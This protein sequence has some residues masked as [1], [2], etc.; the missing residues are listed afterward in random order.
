MFFP[1]CHPLSDEEMEEELQTVVHNF[2]CNAV[3]P[4][5]TAEDPRQF[6][7]TASADYLARE[8]TDD[9]VKELSI[10]DAEMESTFDNFDH[11]DR[12]ERWFRDHPDVWRRPKTAEP[13]LPDRNDFARWWKASRIEIP[14]MQLDSTFQ[15]YLV[16]R[17]MDTEVTAEDT[18]KAIL[19]SY[20]RSIGVPPQALAPDNQQEVFIQRPGLVINQRSFGTAIAAASTLF[21]NDTMRPLRSGEANWPPSLRG[22]QKYVRDNVYPDLS[23]DGCSLVVEFSGSQSRKVTT[24]QINKMHKTWILEHVGRILDSGLT[25]RGEN[26]EKPINILVVAF[27]KAQVTEL[28]IEI[29]SLINQG[30]F[31]KDILTRLKVKT[32]DDAQGDEAD[33]VFVDYV[34]VNHPGFT[35]ESFRGTLA[36]TRARG[37]TILLL[38]RGTFVGY[39]RREESIERSNHLFRIYNWHAS[40]Q[41]VQ[42]FSGCLHCEILDHVTSECKEAVDCSTEEVCERPSCGKKGHNAATCPTR[43]C[44]NCRE[45]G[46]S[47]NECSYDIICS[48]CGRPGH[49]CFVCDF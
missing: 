29:K 20:P 18:P 4:S 39:E 26:S 45:V 15:I 34:A 17:P 31:S 3:L 10:S 41:L 37:M 5:R 8:L 21:Y 1:E 32:L 24:S 38:N 9:E 19:A 43:R 46:H 35:A 30:R 23:S 22:I 44:L 48:R 11:Q 42:R 12:V 14:S 13:P 7:L 49:H 2:F 40:R 28:L 16:S 27:Y 25:G 36:L 33:I 6:M 47:A